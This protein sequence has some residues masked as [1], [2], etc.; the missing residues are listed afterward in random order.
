M[1]RQ[2][3]MVEGTFTDPDKAR[4]AVDELNR[5][6]FAADAVEMEEH[7]GGVFEALLPKEERS[8]RATVR[9]RASRL[10]EAAGVLHR[11]GASDVEREG[12]AGEAG[13]ERMELL[14]EELVPR[15]IPI[16][17]GEVVV[18]K[19]VVTEIKVIEVPV[20]R[21]EIVVERIPLPA[22]VAA[23][24]AEIQ[25]QQIQHEQAPPTAGSETRGSVAGALPSLLGAAEEVIRIPILAEQVVVETRP[26]V[27]EEVRIYKRRIEETQ[28]VAGTVRKEVPVVSHEG[29]VS[30]EERME[31]AQT[32]A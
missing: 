32:T 13:T 26:A 27:V 6:G 10:L 29:D 19:T 25:D 8:G 21:E 16:R 17:I 22:P 30:V 23:G 20:R 2:E 31:H 5:L 1:Q 14:E 18:R 15:T 24:D 7:G 12:A 11:H 28:Q 4:E 3:P 9:V